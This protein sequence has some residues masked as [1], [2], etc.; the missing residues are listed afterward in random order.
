MYFSKEQIEKANAL[1]VEFV[2]KLQ[3][4]AYGVSYA[5]EIYTTNEEQ[6]SI[7]WIEETIETAKEFN[8][9]KMLLGEKH[10]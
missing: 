3:I 5:K 8:L 9:E 10:L 1:R 4:F 6:K 7:S 2:E